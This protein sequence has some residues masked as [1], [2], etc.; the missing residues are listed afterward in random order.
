MKEYNYFMV[1]AYEWQANK[2]RFYIEELF[3]NCNDTYGIVS[4]RTG[5]GKTAL[6]LHLACCLATGTPFLGLQVEKV[7]VGY[8]GFEGHPIN[9]TER[10]EKILRQ[11]PMPESGYLNIEIMNESFSLK[12]NIHKLAEQAQGLKILLIDR[13][14]GLVFSD[15]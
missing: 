13:A 5:R 12:G 7:P 15:R 14:K 10:L 3:P 4:G 2:P 1:D 11:F 8:L 6:L 9:I